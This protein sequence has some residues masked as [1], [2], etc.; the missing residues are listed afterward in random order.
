MTDLIDPDKFPIFSL[1]DKLDFDE[2][3]SIWKYKP[4]IMKKVE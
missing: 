4:E 1:I 3:E 2:L